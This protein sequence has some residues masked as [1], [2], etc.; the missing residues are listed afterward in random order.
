MNYLHSCCL[1]ILI[2]LCSS[3]RLTVNGTGPIITETRNLDHASEIN[4]SIHANVTLIEADSFSC[5]IGAQKNILEV[6][7]TKTDGEEFSIA[8]DRNIDTDKPVEI[9]ISLPKINAINVN[10]SG[11]ISGIKSFHSKDL[12]LEVNG[13]GKIKIS[14]NFSDVKS[15]ISGSGDIY[16]DGKCEQHKINIT[17]SGDFHGY[18]FESANAKIDITGS[19][20]AEVLATDDLNVEITGSG[21]VHYKGNPHLKSDITG[22]GN[23]QKTE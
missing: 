12:K 20:N 10:G 4:L 17:G 13:S 18:D 19:G 5:V 7:K 11:E 2:S 6:I 14:G 8:S 9:V 21:N 22:S 23:I 1:L 3:C 16:L 15:D